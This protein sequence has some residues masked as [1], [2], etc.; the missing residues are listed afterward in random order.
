MSS[1]IHGDFGGIFEWFQ[2]KLLTQY[3][4]EVLLQWKNRKHAWSHLTTPSS[5]AERKSVRSVSKCSPRTFRGKMSYFLYSPK[6][7]CRAFPWTSPQMKLRFKKIT[8]IKPIKQSSPIS[9]IIR[10]PCIKLLNR[11]GRLPH[12]SR[13]WKNILL[14]CIHQL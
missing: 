4:L 11:I 8:F 13:F 5:T 1:W 6:T 9:S 3:L 14:C 7:P 2:Q 10:N 12:R